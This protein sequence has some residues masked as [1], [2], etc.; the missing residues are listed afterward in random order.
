MQSNRTDSPT[1]STRIHVYRY[2]LK[3]DEQKAEY[4]S[5]CRALRNKVALASDPHAMKYDHLRNPGRG[6]RMK[7]NS[8]PGSHYGLGSE[9]KGSIV[10]LE[11]SNLFENQWNTTDESGGRR[12]FDWY[13]G[14]IYNHAGNPNSWRVG[15]YLEI[16]PEMVEIR[17][18]VHK[19]GYCG[20]YADGPGFCEKCLGGPHLEPKDL[21]LLR[22]RPVADERKPREPLTDDERAEIM[23]RYTEAQLRGTGERSKAYAIKKRQEIVDKYE[24]ETAHGLTERDGFLWL[25][26]R[27]LSVENV[28]YYSHTGRFGFGWR[29]PVSDEVYAV[30]VEELCEF[31]YDYDIKRA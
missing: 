3:D 2:N 27:S 17:Q 22:L 25:M 30:L 28:I 15:H 11:T 21:G 13:E 18:R 23:P 8:S 24:A 4:K 9:D 6:G 19:C 12:V 26:D 31:P 16:T 14:I 20:S 1:I 10:E 5:L 7:C 29:T